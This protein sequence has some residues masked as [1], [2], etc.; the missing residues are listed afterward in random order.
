MGGTSYCPGILEMKHQGEWRPVEG[1]SDWNQNSSSVVC[2]QLGC[3]SAV[4]TER[5]S[6]STH[7][8]AWRITSPCVGSETSLK[9]CGT[10][11]SATSLYLLEVIC[12]GNFFDNS[13]IYSTKPWET[14][15][16]DRHCVDLLFVKLLHIYK[17]TC[18]SKARS[19]VSHCIDVI[20]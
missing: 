19:C 13:N 1:W 20:I 17:L 16:P 7:K 6:G 8:P 9:D 4:S 10:K 18:Q 11:M 15:S 3:G 5:S 14:R 2:R 12:S